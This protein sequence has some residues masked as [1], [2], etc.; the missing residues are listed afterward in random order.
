MRDILRQH[1]G[2]HQVVD[3]PG[4]P[5]VRPQHKRMEAPLPG[6]ARRTSAPEPG[7]LR[8]HPVNVWAWE[9][10]PGPGPQL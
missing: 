1:E 4:F 2:R 8:S 9:K 3:G 7:L 6:G 5:T 10:G